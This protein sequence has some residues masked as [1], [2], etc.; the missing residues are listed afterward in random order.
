MLSRWLHVCRQYDAKSSIHYSALQPSN[1]FY[2]C[3]LPTLMPVVKMLW[4]YR[5]PFKLSSGIDTPKPC[6]AYKKPVLSQSINSGQSQYQNSKNTETRL[7]S[8]SNLHTNAAIPSI[9]SDACY[10]VMQSIL[11]GHLPVHIW[12]IGDHSLQ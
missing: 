6:L 1:Y 10:A 2:C 11:T 8:N 12:S 4:L 7:D 5:S 9:T 3:D